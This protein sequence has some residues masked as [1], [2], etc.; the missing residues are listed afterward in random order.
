[1]S[2][3]NFVFRSCESVHEPKLIKESCFGR[4]SVTTP[5]EVRSPIAHVGSTFVALPIVG[6]L[7]DRYSHTGVVK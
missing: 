1:M 3:E 5:D 7:V 2:K 4:V 6:P